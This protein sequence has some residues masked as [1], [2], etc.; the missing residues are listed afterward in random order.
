MIRSP[1]ESMADFSPFFE[2]VNMV[3][4]INGR[5]QRIVRG[6]KIKFHKSM[7]LHIIDVE[8]FSLAI[9][10]LI[11]NLKLIIQI[12]NK[13]CLQIAVR[14]KNAFINMHINIIFLDLTNV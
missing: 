11:A 9:V 14:L 3:S 1:F 13:I 6:I 4:Q 2:S 5:L 10:L 7:S 12:K 8:F